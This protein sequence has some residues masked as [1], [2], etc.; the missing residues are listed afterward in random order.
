MEKEI[1]IGIIWAW[2]VSS[3]T[4]SH[5]KIFVKVTFSYSSEV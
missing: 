1:K 3:E 2:I 4:I 5:Q